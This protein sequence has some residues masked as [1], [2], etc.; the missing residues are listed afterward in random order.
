MKICITGGSGFIGHATIT[1]AESQGHEIWRFD[2]QDGNDVMGDLSALSGA[3]V[4]IH[5]AGMLGTAELFD[6]PE[7]AIQVNVVGSLRVLEWCRKNDA[8]YVGIT[9]PDSSWANVYQATKLCSNRLATAWH[10]NFDIPVS[11]VRAFNVYGP[12]QKHGPGHPRK[13]IPTFAHS[14]WRGVPIP[15]WG[16]GTQTVD[17]IHVDDVAR[18]LVEATSFG[19]DQTFDAGTGEDI[20]VENVAHMV[21]L[22]CDQHPHNVAKSPMRPG[23]APNTQIKATGEG[24]DL[25]GWRPRSSLALL[26]DVV[27]LYRP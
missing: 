23:E 24:W 11:H 9:M 5:L 17:L 14:A 27:D 1:Y 26:K 6:D 8:G 21:N 3:D 19:D 2:R 18:M 20:S 13:I 25:L 22:W 15:I 10:R 12:G 16:D 4:V 7:T